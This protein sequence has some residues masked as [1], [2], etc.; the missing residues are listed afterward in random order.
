MWWSRVSGN[1][2]VHR[3]GCKT[4]P[5]NIKNTHTIPK[6]MLFRFS[7][8][9]K[10]LLQRIRHGNGEITSIG[11]LNLATRFRTTNFKLN[12]WTD[13]IILMDLDIFGA[14]EVTFTGE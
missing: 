11:T 3:T 1:K 9:L 7:N 13:F 4:C 6:N 8:T 2:T 10:A 12:N 5:D 14:T